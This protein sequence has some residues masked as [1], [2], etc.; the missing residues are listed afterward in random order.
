[1]TDNAIIATK[2]VQGF[3]T[4]MELW[5]TM[6]NRLD[7]EQKRGQSTESHQAIVD[8]QRKGIVEI[9]EKYCATSKP[10][11][12]VSYQQPVEYDAQNEPVEAVEVK[13]SRKVFVY[14]KQHTGFKNRMR[15]E[16]V[17]KEDVG[18]YLKSRA[19]EDIDGK[20]SRVQ[21]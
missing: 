10:P 15:Y 12:G 7:R 17:F 20:W 4:E 9:F 2:I 19:F 14:T 6:C 11:R 1:M 16:V 5:E 18:W 13:S 3:I 8:R 21:L